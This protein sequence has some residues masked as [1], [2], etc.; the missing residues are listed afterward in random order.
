MKGY[1]REKKLSKDIYFS[2]NYFSM[3]QLSSLIH[4]LNHI[5]KLKPSSVLEIGIGNGFVSSFLRKAGIDVFTVDINPNLSPDIVS[6]IS[7]L[8]SKLVE[9]KF[10][11][12]VC[13]EVLEHMPFE[14]FEKSIK[15]FKLYSENLFLTLP[16]YDAWFGISGFLKL[17]KYLNLFQ[18]GFKINKKKNLIES[19]HFWELGSCRETSRKNIKEILSSQYNYIEHGTFELNCYHEYYICN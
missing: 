1:E 14:D 16:S 4:Q 3:H 2:E 9:K 13:C 6:P 18:F 8:P 17:P 10:D 15:I 5:Y 11:L 7:E 12:V 19:E